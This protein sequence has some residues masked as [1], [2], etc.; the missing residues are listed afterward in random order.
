MVA[1]TPIPPAP[2][3]GDASP[4]EDLLRPP[5]N[6]WSMDWYHVKHGIVEALRN[7]VAEFHGTVLDVG[8]GR[9]PYKSLVLTPPSRAHTY[10]GLDLAENSYDARP[11]VAWDGEAMPLA[12]RSVNA[13]MLTEVL[14]HCPH[15]DRVLHETARVLVP[16]G[17]CFV[18]VPFLWP[19]HDP[20]ADEYRFTPYA[21]RRLLADAGFERID[22]G[23]FGGWHAAMA[24]ML[25]LW[26][27]RAPMPEFPRRVLRHLLFPVYRLLLDHDRAPIDF[28]TSPMLT[29]LFATARRGGAPYEDAAGPPSGSVS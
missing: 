15:P 27:T 21:L 26:I 25:G 23:A 29:G 18:T 4:L 2:G 22:V 7:V 16:G 20:P 9:S 13:A 12:D 28:S 14:E 17:V 24:Q 5:R 11:D 19:V 1:R 8:C 3:N 6:A 10:V